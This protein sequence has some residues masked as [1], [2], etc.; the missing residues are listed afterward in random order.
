[1]NVRRVSM[2]RF[3][4]AVLMAQHPEGPLKM[5][6]VAEATNIG[7]DTISDIYYGRVKRISVE[8]L[9]RL[10]KF[11]SCSVGDILQYIPD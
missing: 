8:H 7:P 4:L 10:C 11:F 5:K 6:E 2:I 3:K 1:M 9:N